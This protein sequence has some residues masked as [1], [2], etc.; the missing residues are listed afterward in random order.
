MKKPIHKTANAFNSKSQHILLSCQ[1]YPAGTAVLCGQYS[2]PSP[3][4]LQSFLGGLGNVAACIDPRSGI[5]S[6]YQPYI[7][8]KLALGKYGIR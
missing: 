3:S 4:G 2:S 5:S 1:S 6:L 8:T 7:R